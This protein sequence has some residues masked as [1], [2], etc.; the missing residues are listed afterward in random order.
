M[1]AAPIHIATE[2]LM[3]DPAGAVAWPAQRLLAVADLHLERG[4]AAAAR[5]TLLPPW[6]S[7]AT[8]DRLA[9]LLR[10]HRP[11]TLVLLG[12]SFHDRAGA[13]RLAPAERARL[14]RM[15]QGIDLVWVLGNHDPQAPSG[16]PGTATAELVLGRLVFRHQ[17]Q[18]GA[19]NE[20]SGHFHPKA[21]I[22]ARGATVSRPCFV[23][24]GRRLILPALGA[25]A[26]G[27]DVHE[28][29]IARLFPRDGRVFLLGEARLFSFPYAGRAGRLPEGQ[30]ALTL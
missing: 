25:Y 14:V 12:D 21:S 5:G 23:A 10:R 16:L 26:G 22:P 17:A 13:A 15:V 18:P 19:T 8:L 24:D 3:L 2:R 11:R 30:A 27:L 6:D 7:A 4:S 1:I 29:P 28:P 9:L 20:I